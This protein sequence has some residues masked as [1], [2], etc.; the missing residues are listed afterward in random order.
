MLKNSTQE[1]SDIKYITFFLQ[2]YSETNKKQFSR[3]KPQFTKMIILMKTKY[4]PLMIP[5]FTKYFNHFFILKN[6]IKFI[7]R[8]FFSNTKEV[9]QILLDW[10]LKQE[11]NEINH[12]QTLSN[13]NV[14]INSSPNRTNMYSES[15][16]KLYKQFKADIINRIDD[17]SKLEG[18][19]ENEY[20]RFFSGYSYDREQGKYNFIKALVFI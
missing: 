9:N 10:N 1:N 18:L 13:K 19:H 16:L 12:D 5:L 2:N 15:D 17:E 14:V 4:E 8:S 3:T 20:A 7:S 11:F 6:S